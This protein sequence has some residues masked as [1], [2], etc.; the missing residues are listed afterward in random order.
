M[1]DS[2]T[3]LY[4]YG[5][6]PVRNMVNSYHLG[7]VIPLVHCLPYMHSFQTMYIASCI[8]SI[9]FDS[10]GFDLIGLDWIGFDPEHGRGLDHGRG[11]T[12]RKTSFLAATAILYDHHS[13]AKRKLGIQMDGSIE[14]NRIE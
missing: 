4:L 14:L 2:S 8:N 7:R 12:L 9:Q 1:M 10:I 3:V 11:G 6:V 13:K 5:M